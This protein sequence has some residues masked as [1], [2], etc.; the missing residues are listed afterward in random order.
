MYENL[1]LNS[2]ERKKKISS[3][4]R[5]WLTDLFTLDN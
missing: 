1:K 5:K 3:C 4:A 2:C